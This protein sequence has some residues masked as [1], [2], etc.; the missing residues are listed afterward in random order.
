MMPFHE[1]QC[2]LSSKMEDCD[3]SNLAKQCSAMEEKEVSKKLPRVQVSYLFPPKL[4]LHGLL[5]SIPSIAITCIN[6]VLGQTF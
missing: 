2:E 3:N 4:A 1:E 6:F 5:I